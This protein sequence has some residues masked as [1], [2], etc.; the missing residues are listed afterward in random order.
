MTTKQTETGHFPCV[1]SDSVVERNPRVD[2]HAR[3]AFEFELVRFGD[4]DRLDWQQVYKDSATPCQFYD[5]DV[6]ESA[7][8][9]WQSLSGFRVA[10]GYYQGRLCLI[11]PLRETMTESGISVEFLKFPTADNLRPLTIDHCRDAAILELLRYV[12]A[13]ATDGSVS[14]PSVDD[15]FANAVRSEFGDKRVSVV[16]KKSGS[17]LQLPGSIESYWSSLKSSARNQLKRKLRKAE[18]AGLQFRILDSADHPRHKM[19]DT[20]L[21]RL[22]A[23]HRLRFD[24][25]EKK[26]FFV[27]TEMQ[28][29]HGRL[30]ERLSDGPL[31]V[32]FTEC[33][34][35]DS[36]IGSIYGWRDKH[37]YTFLMI[38][39]D[40][41][42]SRYSIGNL[43]IYRT[44]EYLVSKDVQLFDFKCGEESYKTRWTKNRYA[45]H[46][47]QVQPRR[48]GDIISHLFAG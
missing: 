25:I 24:S 35:G 20:A 40:P 17:I 15:S 4:V 42:H 9:A 36:V 23:L 1:G 29:F 43:L 38:G 37:Q 14:F 7:L 41:D 31:N 22:T 30:V 16:G 13:V 21:P 26:S 6:V 12:Q 28:L 8:H 48:F 46:D 33:L 18:E 39:F 27:G 45:V 32:V 47:L 3:V 10:R 44:I 19:L 34:S 11:Q 2:E 5:Y